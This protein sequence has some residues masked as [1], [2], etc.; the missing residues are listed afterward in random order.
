MY[1]IEQ[2][3]SNTLETVER[4]AVFTSTFIPT[5]TPYVF[6]LELDVLIYIL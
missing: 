6:I 4:N 2:R 3:M 1:I 5:Q